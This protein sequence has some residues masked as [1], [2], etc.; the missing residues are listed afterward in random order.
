MDETRESSVSGQAVVKV[1]EERQQL[2]GVRTDEVTH[3]ELQGTIRTTGTLAYDET[4]VTEIHTKIAGWAE[5]VYVD[6]IGKPVRRGQPLF[7]IYSPELVSTQNEYLLARRAQAALSKSQFEETRKGAESLLAA[8]LDRLRLWDIS[9]AQIQELERT[10]QPSRT[11]TLY[12]PFDG[13]VLERNVFAGQYV[14]PEMMT[15]KIADLSRIWVIGQIFE[16]ESRGIEVGQTV[17]VEFP[18]EQVTRKLAGRITFIYPD[19]D[20]MTRR[21]RVRAEF[22]NPGWALKPDTFVTLVIQGP[23]R[24]ELAVPAEAV[25]DTGAKRYAIVDR[26]NGYFEPREIETG[27]P[28]GGYYPVVKGLEHG[29][30]VVTSAQFLIDSESNLAAAMKAMMAAMPGMDMSGMDMGH[31]GHKQ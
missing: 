8:T 13:V 24:M 9:A 3:R 6:F 17:T 2:I 26:G 5:H 11:L 18:Y 1:P 30:R 7:T 25:I 28:T 29:D 21:V 12:T 22:T 14:T 16:Y 19:V 20:P 10:G 15:F 23:T 4:R 27:A 31:S